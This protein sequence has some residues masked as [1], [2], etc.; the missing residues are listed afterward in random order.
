MTFKMVLTSIKV[1][2]RVKV[3]VRI[4]VCKIKSFESVFLLQLHSKNKSRH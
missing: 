3:G 4:V 1:C 2:F